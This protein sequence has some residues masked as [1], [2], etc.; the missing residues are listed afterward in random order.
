[1]VT[2]SRRHLE[3]IQVE[4]PVTCGVLMC[5]A[6]RIEGRIDNRALQQLRPNKILRD[7]IS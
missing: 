3:R 4:D 2:L 1:M 5:D 7:L 6:P